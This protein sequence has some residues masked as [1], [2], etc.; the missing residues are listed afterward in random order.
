MFLES[1]MRYATGLADLSP[2]KGGSGYEETHRDAMAWA[3]RFSWDNAA[4]RSWSARNLK[5]LSDA[6]EAS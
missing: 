5:A 2:P 4:V 3:G 1:A 6:F